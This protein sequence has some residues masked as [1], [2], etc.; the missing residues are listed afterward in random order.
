MSAAGGTAGSGA[1]VTPAAL[2]LGRAADWGRAPSAHNT[3]PWDVRTD[4]PD[5][6]VLGWH[7]DR[8]LTIGDATRRDLL[9]SLGCVAEA[10]SIVAADEGY[11]VH[12]RWQV[13]H[14]R[15]LAGRL[16]L[17]AD[18]DSGGRAPAAFTVA[19]LLARRTAR[20][21]YE[22]PFV[23]PEQVADLAREAGLAMGR[24]DGLVPRT[25]RPEV[26]RTE[27]AEVPRLGRADDPA[28][29]TDLLVLPPD[30]VESQVREADRW[31]FDG[32]AT[33]ELREWLRLDQR[34]PAYAR[35]GLSD[36]ALGLASWE[37]IG[38]N[39]ALRPA[40]LSLLR[41]TRLTALLGRTATDQ[42]VGTVVALTAAPDLTDEQV[43]A[44]GRHLLRVWL[45]AGRVGLS[46]HPLSQ[47]L[48][49]PGTATEVKGAVGPDRTAY[50]V[51]R[52]GRPRHR[53]VRS[54]RV[55]D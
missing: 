14:G 2:L 11:A 10:I 51:F 35:D 23:T 22:S 30:L 5:T 8:V 18:A 7:A 1:G 45:A 32:P 26:P 19:E 38:L 53:P 39:L 31:T 36:T 28:P 55:T 15:G 52:L 33:G 48:D 16:E 42:P 21:A 3:Q 46:A 12:P 40:V 6:L 24:P 49:C 50:S 25:Q 27:R 13:D 34:D 29:L 43:L 37:R 4:G 17:R 54:A 44:C 41:R 47:L 9:L 20:A